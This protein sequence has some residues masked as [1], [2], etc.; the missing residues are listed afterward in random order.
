MERLRFRNDDK[1][2]EILMTW[3]KDL[4][5]HTAARA[6]LRRAQTPLD[7]ARIGYFHVLISRLREADYNVNLYNS[8]AVAIAAALVARI[9]YYNGRSTFAKQ[10]SEKRRGTPLISKMRL[11]RILDAEEHEDIVRELSSAIRI[12]GERANILDLADGIVNWNDRV[13]RD[14]L[15][16]YYGNTDIEEKEKTIWN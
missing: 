11:K 16:R 10:M 1:A 12:M 13:R 15:Y 9:R 7:V 14:W 5:R 8:D 3:R 4:A 6:E 2:C